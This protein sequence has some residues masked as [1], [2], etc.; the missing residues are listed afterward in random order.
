MSVAR[1]VRRA[2][3][4]AIVERK[5][6][7]PTKGAPS[8]GVDFFDL[9]GDLE[10][11]FGHPLDT[12]RGAHPALH[13]GQSAEVWVDGRAIGWIG[14]LHPRLVQAFDLSVAPVLFEL[15]SQVISQR[16]LPRHASLSRFPLVRRDLAFVLDVHTP[17][18]ELLE[19]LRE[20]APARV[21]SIEVFDDYRGKGMTENQKSLA[22]RVVMQDTE[23]TL[24]DQDVEDAMQ[25]L[26]SA[27]LRQCNASLRA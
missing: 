14:A 8:R 13:P 23:R 17:A 4:P 21:Q 15:D 20:V 3:R 22:I 11:L 7:E 24:T 6:S 25:K 19:A 2:S 26:V 18:G 10:R 16:V 9:K 27:A 5:S 1:A 12:R